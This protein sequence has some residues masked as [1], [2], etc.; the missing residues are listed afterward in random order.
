MICLSAVPLPLTHKYGIDDENRPTITAFVG[1]VK[2]WFQDFR[3]EQFCFIHVFVI[4]LH[5][6]NLKIYKIK[7]NF[8]LCNASCRNA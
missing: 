2:N 7:L 1:N 5:V 4:S 8:V 3:D 6:L